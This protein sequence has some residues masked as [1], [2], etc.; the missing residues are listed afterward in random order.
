MLKKLRAPYRFAP[1]RISTSR[2]DALL[3]QRA[4]AE[5]QSS[6][7]RGMKAVDLV[8]FTVDGR[9]VDQMPISGHVAATTRFVADFNKVVRGRGLAA[10]GE[11]AG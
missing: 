5:L 7:R 6:G 4:V 11:T 3:A 9:I 2:I 1:A 8:T 10:F